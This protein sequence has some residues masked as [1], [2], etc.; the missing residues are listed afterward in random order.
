MI[1]LPLMVFAITFIEWHMIG[2]SLAFSSSGS[3]FIGDFSNALLRGILEEN[4]QDASG[5]SSHILV[6][7][8]AVL[9]STRYESRFS[10]L[11]L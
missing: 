1:V 4:I 11:M 9:A 2:F 5:L 7:R 3:K 8:Q 10:V 6:F